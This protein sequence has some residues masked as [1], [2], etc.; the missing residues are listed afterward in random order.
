MEK[1]QQSDVP[2]QSSHFDK[3]QG[4]NT[5]S[6]TAGMSKEDMAIT[7]TDSDSLWEFFSEMVTNDATAAV[8][9]NLKEQ[10][11]EFAHSLEV[12]KA[13]RRSEFRF[14]DVCNFPLKLI[15]TPLQ[16]GRK[17]ANVFFA[18]KMEMQFGPLHAALQVGNVVLEWNNSHLVSPYLCAHEDQVMEL[19][20]QPH[21]K[22]VEY[23]A[24]HHPKMRKAAQAMDY[25][26]QIEL[27]YP[28]RR[29]L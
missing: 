27:T 17:V 11:L 15:L 24:Q 2:T 8:E 28:K 4:S 9:A 16:R 6:N 12:T 29:M 10:T 22:W 5:G 1:P 21:S 13:K 25:S 20:M 3:S 23:T 14:N 19:D 18:R 7:L 26:E